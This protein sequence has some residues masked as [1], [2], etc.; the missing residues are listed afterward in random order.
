MI[1]EQ[2]IPHFNFC[3]GGPRNYSARPVLMSKEPAAVPW[4]TLSACCPGGGGGEDELHSQSPVD[5]DDEGYVIGG[6]PHG[7]EHNDHGGESCLRDAGCPDAGCRGCDAAGGAGRARGGAE[8]QGSLSGQDARAS[9]DNHMGQGS[10]GVLGGPR[11][12]SHSPVGP[13]PWPQQKLPR[14]LWKTECLEPRLL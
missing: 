8:G 4:S 2:G 13:H 3:K 14:S 1:F 7:G 12:R 5:G 10:S 9:G 11:S 6:K